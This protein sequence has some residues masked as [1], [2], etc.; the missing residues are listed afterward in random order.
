M[1]ICS[2]GA[3]NSSTSLFCH[4]CG[5]PLPNETPTPPRRPYPVW[6]F[7]NNLLVILGIALAGCT[8]LMARVHVNKYGI[9]TYYF[10]Y[11]G[12]LLVLLIGAVGVLLGIIY[13]IQNVTKKMGDRDIYSAII[14]IIRAAAVL[15]VGIIMLVH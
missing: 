14:S 1:K 12:S 2:C 13:L 5:K 6:A 4:I 11:T 3:Q 8:W 7:V 15:T 9:S 10:G